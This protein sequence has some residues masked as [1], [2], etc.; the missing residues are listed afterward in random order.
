MRITDTNN[1][2]FKNVAEF[3]RLDELPIINL[4]VRQFVQCLLMPELNPVTSLRVLFFSTT[5]EV[6]KA[7]ELKALQQYAS[8]ATL[9]WST[10]IS[11]HLTAGYGKLSEYGEWEFQLPYDFTMWLYAERVCA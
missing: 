9:S 6:V 3:Y 8:G 1:E 10:H 11:E 4:N 2:Q 7:T 5:P